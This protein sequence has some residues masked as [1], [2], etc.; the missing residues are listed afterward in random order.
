M[1]KPYYQDDFC[2]IYHG[3]AQ[4]IVPQLDLSELGCVLTDPPY[5]IKHASMRGASWRNTQIQNDTDTSERD[6]LIEMRPCDCM[7]VFGT[8]K[9][10][11]PNGEKGVLVWDKGP[12]TGMGDLKFPWKLSWEM[13]WMF[14][15]GWQWNK[16]EEGI[17]RGHTVS[18][19]ESRGR[20]HPHQ[21]PISLMKHLALRAPKGV[22]LDPYMGSGST[23]RAMKDMGRKSI[24]VE[25]EEHYC[26]VA[27]ERLSQEMIQFPAAPQKEAVESE[28]FLPF[29]NVEVFRHHVIESD[30]AMIVETEDGQIT[31][32]AKDK[33]YLSQNTFARRIASL[34]KGTRND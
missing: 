11:P 21:K 28:E 18:S 7:A 29:D 16:R 30:K 9:V 24:G 14:G 8:H 22:V 10:N 33:D 20:R 34:L 23:L 31:T 1:I 5:G 3:S 13:I 19:W 32:T 2:I 17:L 4:E 6:W 25:L 27:V 26:E 15:E 12:T